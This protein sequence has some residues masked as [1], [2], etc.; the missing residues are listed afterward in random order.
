VLLVACA[1]GVVAAGSRGL[2][3]QSTPQ[4]KDAAVQKETLAERLAW[5]G[6]VIEG[7]S[8]ELRDESGR[9]ESFKYEAFSF[10]DCAI[11]WRETN[12]VS[13][14]GKFSAKEIRRVTVPLDTL[15][16]ASIRVDKLNDNL[17]LVSFT[18]VDMSP[19]ILLETKSI[20]EDGSEDESS[21]SITGG[22]I[23]FQDG[24]VADRVAKA[25]VFGVK[26]CQK[27]N[28]AKP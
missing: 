18:I 3:W 13:K 17:Y 25:L 19:E 5:M 11:S 16:R 12:E 1:S 6:G 2:S 9:H 26:S 28:P 20:S 15:D 24:D 22:G 8:A 27:A 10:K 7:S 21:S 23:Y 14:G 4:A